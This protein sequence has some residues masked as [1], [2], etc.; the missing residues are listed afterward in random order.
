MCIIP[1]GET[2]VNQKI[3]KPGCALHK[4]AMNSDSRKLDECQF[5]RDSDMCDI[6]QFTGYHNDVACIEFHDVTLGRTIVSV[7]GPKR[8]LSMSV[9]LEKRSFFISDAESFVVDFKAARSE[10]NAVYIDTNKVKQRS[11]AKNLF[12]TNLLGEEDD[13]MNYHDYVSDWKRDGELGFATW[14]LRSKNLKIFKSHN[15]NDT[16]HFH[17]IEMTDGRFDA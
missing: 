17:T 5:F 1:D 6:I 16:E 10:S 7:I 15:T 14:S 3:I 11:Q 2:C 13:Y 4:W 9:T 12:E 8:L